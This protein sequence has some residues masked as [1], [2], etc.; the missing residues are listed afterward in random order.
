[1]T[2]VK[3]QLIHVTLQEVSLMRKSLQLDGKKSWHRKATH[4]SQKKAEEK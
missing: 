1:M 2:P 4:F 3:E